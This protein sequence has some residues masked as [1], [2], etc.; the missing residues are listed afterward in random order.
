ML[1]ELNECWYIYVADCFS[2]VIE[3]V[4]EHVIVYSGYSHFL[5]PAVDPGKRVSLSFKLNLQHWIA[6]KSQLT[7]QCLLQP[8]G[9]MQWSFSALLFEIILMRD[10]RYHVGLCMQKFLGP[11]LSI[12][13]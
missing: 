5:H 8:Q 4:V 9:L 12:S 6:T 11:T 1:P 7:Q 3:N 13:S 2:G 10:A